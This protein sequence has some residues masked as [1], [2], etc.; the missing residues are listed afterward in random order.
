MKTK[1]NTLF[2]GLS[3]F[4]TLWAT[5]SLSALGSGMTGYA[6]ILWSYQE[7]G[8]ALTTALLSIC[9]YTPYVIFSVFAGALSDK[10][11][12]KHT[13]LVCDSTAAL[14][15][16]LV[17]VLFITGHLEIW[18][19]YIINAVSGL[20]NTIQ[21]PASD[22]SVS[23]LTPKEQY[24]RVSGMKS[25]SNSLNTILTPVI[26]TAV[27]TFAGMQG[28]IAF[29]LFTFITAFI[30][31]AFFI[32]IP[33]KKRDSDVQE[34]S[35]WSSVKAGLSY[36]Q[37]NRGILD[38]ILFLAA[39]N[40]IAS[41]YDAA[42]PAM[43][44]SR[45]G[46]STAALGL[47]NT[48]TGLASLT[49]SILVS[50]MP[51]PKSRVR[52]ICNSLLFSMSFENFLLAFGRNIPV[53]CLGAVLG[54]LMIPV[55]NANMDVLFRTHIPI[56]MQ[57]RVY[58]ARNTFQFFT[59]PLGSFLGGLFVDKVFEP[60]M[61]AQGADSFFI[62]LLGSGKGSGAAL[63]FL[64]LAFAGIAVCL[65]FRKDRHLWILDQKKAPGNLH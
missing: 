16:V 41:M 42:L 12:K 62:K 34:E 36:L 33:E 29:D 48:F 31:L 27:F 7:K 10:W 11:N 3:A 32:R 50:L 6:L 46:G 55:M 13:M 8:S 37:K 40:L 15:T 45:D 30:T 61:A 24:Q 52:V 21:Q 18:H 58:S 35:I 51:A 57:G 17:L 22:V 47:V 14:T 59:I 60:F 65:I 49:G 2:K 26:A 38:L 64:V 19:L 43:L 4:I 9:S 23:L 1:L 25:F 28:V 54:W 44:L 39:I 5:Q 63:L 20:M 53:W 56:E